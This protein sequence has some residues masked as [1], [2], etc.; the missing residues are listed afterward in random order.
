MGAIKVQNEVIKFKKGAKV[1][2]MSNTVK[3]TVDGTITTV[4]NASTA[5]PTYVI[6][7]SFEGEHHHETVGH[8]KQS[9]LTKK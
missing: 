9:L 2:F 8:G 1:S 3:S 6:A 7:F 4:L 5:Y